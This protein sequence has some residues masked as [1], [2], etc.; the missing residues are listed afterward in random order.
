MCVGEVVGW[1]WWLALGSYLRITLWAR[2]GN[3]HV[4]R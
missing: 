4:V 3:P 2:A 1:E